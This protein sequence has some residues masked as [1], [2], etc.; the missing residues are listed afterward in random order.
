M[1]NNRATLWRELLGDV[2]ETKKHGHASLA[3]ALSDT[4]IVGLYFSAHWCGPCREFTPVLGAKY[5]KLKAVH[6]E[7]EVLYVSSD[8]T[9]AEFDATF[10]EMPF[11]G[12]PFADRD[13]KTA[14][15][16]HFRVP[17]LPFLVFVNAHGDVLERDGRRLFASARSVETVWDAL[18]AAMS[19]P[20][21]KS[22]NV[23]H[24]ISRAI[25]YKGTR[26]KENTTTW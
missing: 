3:D 25:N 14:L 7:F 1:D 26:E 23:R 4:A 18:T 16:E 8:R 19:S 5:E 12:L 10:G 11:L 20:R 9:Q 22:H 13:M 15:V 24:E 2:V 6:P 17:W 21:E